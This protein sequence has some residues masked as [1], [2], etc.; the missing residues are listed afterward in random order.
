L[1]LT[2]TPDYSSSISS[3]PGSGRAGGAADHDA[4]LHSLGRARSAVSLFLDRS[5]ERDFSNLDLKMLPGV[6]HFAHRED[7][8]RMSEEIA[9]FFERIDWN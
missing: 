5:P 7:P 1:D 3:I 9:A 4:D 2:S 6:G 8:D